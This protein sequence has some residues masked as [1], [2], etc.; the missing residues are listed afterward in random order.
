VAIVACPVE[1]AGP[2]A[3]RS[4]RAGSG[5]SFAS[6][7][8]LAPPSPFAQHAQDVNSGDGSQ[9]Q[10]LGNA[11]SAVSSG[12]LLGNMSMEEA[13]QGSPLSSRHIST[14]MQT[15]PPMTSAAASRHHS[16][17]TASSQHTEDA[18]SSQQHAAQAAA[19][20]TLPSTPQRSRLE[21]ID[22]AF[23]RRRGGAA[24]APTD[25]DPEQEVRP[26]AQLS[27]IAEQQ[28]GRES[29]AEAG[30]AVGPVVGQGLH[31]G[32]SLGAQPL[33]AAA[34]VPPAVATSAVPIPMTAPRQEESSGFTPVR[35]SSL[36]N[37]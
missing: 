9:L 23:G 2:G 21:R 3:S 1:L 17:D 34:A 36:Q 5:A 35:P 4:E 22:T 19:L 37:W 13:A 8:Q 12:A 20:Q 10:G 30:T 32:T 11:S 26:A 14:A 7:V 18:A 28:A 33:A 29:A 31:E 16:S 24:E 6:H 27:G 25:A 15:D